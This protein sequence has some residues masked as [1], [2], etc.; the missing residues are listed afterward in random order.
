[1]KTYSLFFAI[2]LFLCADTASAQKKPTKG[3]KPPTSSPVGETPKTPKEKPKE[4]DPPDTSKMLENIGLLDLEGARDGRAFATKLQEELQKSLSVP[5]IPKDPLSSLAESVKCKT[6]EPACLGYVAAYIG[7]RYLLY[8]QSKSQGGKL[9]LELHLYDAKSPKEIIEIKSDITN[10][11]DTVAVKTISNQLLAAVPELRKAP[12][13]PPKPKER[14]K[15]ISDNSVVK[16][17]WFWTIIGG[18]VAGSATGGY[19]YTTR[20]PDATTSDLGTFPASK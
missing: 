6:S 10:V 18:G 15:L 13:E 7:A 20:P 11:S 16:R 12:P 4:K 14:K 1:M 19:L 17:W 8:G 2:A 9:A 3:K 5:L